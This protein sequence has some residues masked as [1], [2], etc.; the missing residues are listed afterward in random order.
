MPRCS[1]S[2]YPVRI[3]ARFLVQF[4]EVVVLGAGVL[5]LE[6]MGNTKSQIFP[7][8]KNLNMWQFMLIPVNQTVL[9]GNKG[10]SKINC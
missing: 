8:Y 5:Q 2:R 6:I 7:D 3:R 9:L 10:L 1:R 4:Y